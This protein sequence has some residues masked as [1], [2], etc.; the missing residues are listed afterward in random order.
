MNLLIRIKYP[1]THDR[2]IKPTLLLF[3]RFFLSLFYSG[4]QTLWPNV[5]H[6]MSSRE[7]LG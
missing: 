4:S 5:K 3:F 2:T 6:K 7:Y 1:S